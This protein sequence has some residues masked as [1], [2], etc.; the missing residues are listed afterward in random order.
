MMFI[1]GVLGMLEKNTGFTED[2]YIAMRKGFDKH[3]LPAKKFTPAMAAQTTEAVD[4]A[5]VIERKGLSAPS[6]WWK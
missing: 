4:T 1:S 3:S 2:K 5:W 6:L